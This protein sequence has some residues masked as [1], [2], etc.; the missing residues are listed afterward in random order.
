MRD[1]PC[2]HILQ[3]WDWG[4]FKRETGRWRP[5]RLAFE[6][7]GKIAATASLL[8]R[9]IGP[10][11]V[12]YVSK[13]PALDYADHALAARVF[14]E[15]ENYARQFGVVWLKIDP[16]VVAGTGLPGS[17]E[18]RVCSGGAAVETLLKRRGWRFAESQVQFRNTLTIDLRR[19]EG[20]ILAAMSGN[21]RRKI[22]LAAKRGVAIRPAG[23]G[24]LPLLYQLYA[25][26]SER[27]GFTIRPFDYYRRAWEQ[28]L[29]AGLAQ[30]LIAEYDGEAVAHV[31]LFHFGRKCW[32]FYGASANEERERMP[33][34]ALQWA[35]IQWAK[36]QGYETYDMWGAPE[37]FDESD[38]MWGVYRFKRGFRG[39]LTRYIGAW[40]FAA[41]A[42]LYYLYQ[43]AVPRFLGAI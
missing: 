9:R 37:V 6:R 36:A 35:A 7:R 18:D 2:S 5:L 29:R 27:D 15:L 14:A 4:E 8:T 31:I 33:N 43:Q 3:T 19:S 25:V 13:G 11:R 1:L 39:H 30:A 16:D 41:Q 34:Y 17:A 40:D 28:F 38:P 21:T 20:E 32:Y 22:R 24:D 26:T 10:L 42:T 23:V 12:I